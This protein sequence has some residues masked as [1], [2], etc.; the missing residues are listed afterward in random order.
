MPVD[1]KV[2]FAPVEANDKNV[3]AA[4]RAE[5]L[6]PKVFDLKYRWH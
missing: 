4:M 6:D 5:Y 1:D 2:T 3:L